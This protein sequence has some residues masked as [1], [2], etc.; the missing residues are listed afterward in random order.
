MSDRRG[1]L[2]VSAALGLTA[3]AAP[4][5]LVRF[6]LTG[7]GGG[8]AALCVLGLAGAVLVA[9]RL[10]GDAP[11]GRLGALRRRWLPLL[12]LAFLVNGGVRTVTLAIDLPT[13]APVV[14]VTHAVATVLAAALAVLLVGP[15]AER[16]AAAHRRASPLRGSE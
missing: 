6:A 16:L 3:V 4:V 8:F 13:E 5:A 2:A 11:E 7:Q 1:I 12:L 10:A 9:A 14:A 15:A